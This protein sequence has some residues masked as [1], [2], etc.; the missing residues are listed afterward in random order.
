MRRYLRFFFRRLSREKTLSIVNISGLSISIGCSILIF[1]WVYNELHFESFHHNKDRLY[2]IYGQQ[3]ING[4]IETSRFMPMN[5]AP[6]LRLNYPQIERISRINDARS[7]ILS[8]GD[9]HIAASGYMV[10][11]DFL[12]MF[13]FLR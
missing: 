12:K 5:L 8:A 7:F 1:L 11:S 3:K 10:D 2:E 9:N 6:L 4:V 13:T